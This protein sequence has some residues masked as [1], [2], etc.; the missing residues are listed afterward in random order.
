MNISMIFCNYAVSSGREITQHTTV[1]AQST[2]HTLQH[3]SHSTQHTLKQSTQHTSQHTANSSQH[4]TLQLSSLHTIFPALWGKPPTWIS[5]IIFHHIDGMTLWCMLNVYRT[6]NYPSTAIF[7]KLLL[8]LLVLPL[9]VVMVN[10]CH[11][12]LICLFKNVHHIT[13]GCSLELA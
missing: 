8:V 5:Q 1:E 11:P 7:L 3:T 10:W 4:S 12:C 13:L 6:Y 9:L 2:Q